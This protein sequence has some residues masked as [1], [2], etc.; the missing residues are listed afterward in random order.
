MA[1]SRLD[2][3]PVGTKLNTML[4]DFP[5]PSRERVTICLRTS[6]PYFTV[7]GRRPRTPPTSS[8]ARHVAY[9]SM[10]K[11]FEQYKNRIL[12]SSWEGVEDRGR[13]AWRQPLPTST[14][15]LSCPRKPRGRCTIELERRV[16]R[17][18]AIPPHWHGPRPKS[19]VAAEQSLKLPGA[20]K[21]SEAMRSM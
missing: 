9:G 7:L 11:Q 5:F 19:C 6:S 10:P 20:L 4:S 14:T 17:S 16:N 2:W 18:I 15:F 1:A 21:P 13:H 8:R 3:A 12:L